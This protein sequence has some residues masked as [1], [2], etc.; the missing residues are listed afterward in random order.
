MCV[1]LIQ[2]IW[3]NVFHKWTL[4]RNEWTIIEWMNERLDCCWSLDERASDFVILNI[5]SS[6]DGPTKKTDRQAGR[7]ADW[8][9]DQN[10]RQTGFSDFNH[11]YVAWRTD[12][13]DRQIGRQAD[14]LIDQPKRQTDT[15]EGRPTDPPTKNADRQA[16]R[17]TDWS[18]DQ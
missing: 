4:F 8:S 3:L 11:L 5:C 12:Q 17:K 9:T 18:T 2:I 1:P 14:K 16:G 13:K 7:Q 6:S 15:Q 10:D